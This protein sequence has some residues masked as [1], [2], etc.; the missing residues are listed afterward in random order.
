[1]NEVAW[2]W[3]NADNG[4]WQIADLQRDVFG[5]VVLVT[6]Y[7]GQARRGFAIRA[8][9]VDSRATLRRL[10]R[11]L[12]SRRR[13]HAYLRAS[14]SRDDYSKGNRPTRP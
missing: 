9:P 13:R 4:R 11:Q 8:Y 14:V 2:H 5:G 1:M 10:L 12:G 6:R 7:G 3:A